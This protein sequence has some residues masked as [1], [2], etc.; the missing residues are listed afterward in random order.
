[1]SRL[2]TQWLAAPVFPGDEEKTRRANLLHMTLLMNI[3]AILI[4]MLGN[5]LGGKIPVLVQV[6]DFILLTGMVILERIMRR[7]KIM[8]ASVVL[9]LLEFILITAGI[10]TLGTIRT[11]TTSVYVLI[12]L[13][14]GFLFDLPGILITSAV[15]SLTLLGLI[16]AE[17]AGWLPSS[18]FSVTLTQWTTYTVYFVGTG[19]LSFWGSRS[20]RQSLT[21]AQQEIIERKRVEE[22]LRESEERYRTL[23]DNLPIPIFTKDI[24]GRYLTCNPASQRYWHVNPI[25]HT[26]SELLAP[27]IANALRQADFQILEQT[28]P[29]D[30]EEKFHSSAGEYTVLSHKVP[31]RNKAGQIIGI[32]G[33]SVDIT[34]RKHAEEQLRESEARFRNFV[35]QSSEGFTLLDEQGAI[36][37]WNRACEN[38]TGLTYAE[39][40]GEKFW[41]VQQRSLPPE[42]Q[43][44]QDYARRKQAFQDALQTGTSPLF[45]RT[46]E[47]QLIQP[48]GKRR[49]FRQTVF[50]IKT[51]RG[52]QIGLVSYEITERKRLE[53]ELQEQ[54][55]FAMTVMNNMGQGLTVTNGEARFEYVNQAYARIVGCDPSELIGQRP[56]DVTIQEDQTIVQQALEDRRQGKTTSYESRFRRRDGTHVHALVTGVP[57]VKDGEYGGTIAVITD[58]TERNRMEGAL[59]ASEELYHQM[60]ADHSAIKLVLDPESG[61]IVDANLAAVEFYGYPLD[62]LRQMNIRQINTLPYDH[63]TQVLQDVFAHKQNYFLFQ[64]R[65]ASGEIREV[66]VYAVPIQSHNR[67]VLY[68]IIHDITAR[69]LVETQLQY[70]GSHDALTGLYNRSF[71]E[72]EMARLNAS[73]EFPISLMISDF[74]NLKVTNDTLGHAAGDALLKR[75]VAVFHAS[76]RTDDIIARIGGD[77]FAILLPRTDAATATEILARMKNKI[78]EFNAQQPNPPLS[79]SIGIATTEHGN[80][81]ETF[82]LAD[83]R[84]YA[85]KHQRKG[86]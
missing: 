39:V 38:I 36:I 17:N 68:A 40:K 14:A 78:A 42:A 50:P 31:L 34:E 67:T 41:D 44:P 64:H 54:R 9:I 59:R 46:F 63:V 2:I 80:L 77:E 79:L 85:D 81:E 30:L 22:Q 61:A 83:S 18:N 86:D 76:L 29:L 27:A 58:L 52:F 37:E 51:E 53:L 23:V 66:E 24:Q 7:G 8:F 48:D 21:R 62:T 15:C 49:L 20:V 45:K 1:M 11:P 16:T 75:V 82:R 70:L 5:A 25:G 69:R 12:I 35:E 55:D 32:L 56:A 26:D 4:A 43:T 3:T 19:C 72:T 74:D 84:M 73:Q 33:A 6:I 13:F 71:F 65:L 28:A 60:F 10:I 47:D 57:R